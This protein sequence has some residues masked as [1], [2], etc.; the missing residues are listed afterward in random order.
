M[1]K[2]LPLSFVLALLSFG[3]KVKAQCDTTSLSSDLI[4][5]SDQIMSGVYYIDGDFEIQQG[6][7][8]YVQSYDFGACGAL[9][10]HANNVSV[11]GTIDG[12]YAGYPGGDGG[13][14]ASQ[15]NSLT[16]DQAA[17]TGCSNKDNPG[18][19][20]VTGGLPGGTGNG[21]GAGAEGNAGTVGSGPKQICETTDDTYGMFGGSGGAGGGGGGAYGSDAGDAMNGGA[22]SGS[23]NAT[24]VSIS[25]S[26]SVVAGQGGTGGIGGSENGT[27]SGW[28]I[29]LGSG[30]A[31]GGGGG[32]SFDQGLAGGSGGAGGGLVKLVANDSLV[33]TGLIK[34]N[35][36]NG[37]A[38]GNGGS[39][40]ATSKCCSDGCNDCGEANFSAGAGA[41]SGGGG[42]SG[43][44]ILLESKTA[45]RI[46]GTLE[47]KGGNG[48]NGGSQGTGV[49][50]SYNNIICGDQTIQTGDGFDGNAGGDGSGGRIKIFVPECAAAIVS[51]THD[52]VGGN[53]STSFEGT[54]EE[55]C[56]YVSLNEVAEK[57]K[58]QVYP[59]PAQEQLFIRIFTE[60][61]D[62]QISILDMSGRIVLQKQFVQNQPIQISH[63]TKG[64]YMVRLTID[65]HQSIEKVVI[66]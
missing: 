9:E 46:V 31:G 17:L 63:F 47:S 10:I 36:E 52:V 51:P 58:F 44:G 33:V 55:I 43:G 5:S 13:L 15:V 21:P 41:G 28:D 60:N 45:A 29:N 14:Q 7:T 48:G 20:E 54:Y 8:V 42:G 24:G 16:G 2:L 56:G 30:G 23:H 26:Y 32:R 35:G 6:V 1:K 38:G 49:S 64:V 27:A 12:D 22:G 39:G 59:N 61:K 3:V 34:V 66:Q 57:I 4:I 50:C 37:A 53:G 19:V 18:H 11:K 65:G 25:G 40:G 62:A